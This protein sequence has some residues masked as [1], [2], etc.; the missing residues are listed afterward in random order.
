MLQ[1]AHLI[2]IADAYKVAAGVESDTTVSN[3][4]FGDTKKLSAL[5][6]GADI[7]VGRFNS[8][9]DWFRSNW[10][11]GAAMPAILS[12]SEP[13][14]TQSSTP[15]ASARVRFDESVNPEGGA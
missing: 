5:R 7:T 11:A 1:V 12:P 9:F 13:E 2:S 4:V 10:P 15:D 3:R 8:A 6:R 14:S